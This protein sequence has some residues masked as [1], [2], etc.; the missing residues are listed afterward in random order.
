MPK[1][2]HPEIRVA[3][4]STGDLGISVGCPNAFRNAVFRRLPK[5][6]F[7]KAI[8]APNAAVVMILVNCSSVANFPAWLFTSDKFWY[9]AA[10]SGVQQLA[11]FIKPRLPANWDNFC[12]EF[13]TTEGFRKDRGA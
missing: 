6:N 8:M 3:P 12:D 1:S 4:W 5:R 7:T 10:S 11:Y 2:T 13:G 9:P